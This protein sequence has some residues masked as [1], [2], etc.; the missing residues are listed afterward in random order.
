MHRRLGCAA[1]VFAALGLTSPAAPAVGPHSVIN[2]S[3]ALVRAYNR[4]DADALHAMLAPSLKAK[5][6]VEALSAPQRL[7]RGLTHENFRLS[8]PRWGGRRDGEFA[9]YAETKPFEMHIEIDDDEKIIHWM[10]TDDLAS[11]PQ[12]CRVSYLD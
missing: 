3:E 5:H 7:C 11:E 2:V 1:A 8:T 12:Q 6:T 10:I 9:G 4:E